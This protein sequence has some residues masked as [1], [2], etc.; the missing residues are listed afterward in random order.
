[1]ERRPIV[2]RDFVRYRERNLVECL[3][4]KIKHYRGIATPYDKLVRNFLAAVQ[5]AAAIALLN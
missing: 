2:R 5:L 4:N 3:F 1:M